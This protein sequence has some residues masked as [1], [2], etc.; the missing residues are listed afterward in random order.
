MNGKYAR[1]EDW[2]THR[3]RIT[4]LYYRA[5]MSLRLVKQIMQDEHSFLANERMYKTRIKKWNL[6]K[7]VKAGEIAA[8][9]RLKRDA[10]AGIQKEETVLALRDRK[11]EWS[12]VENHLK[13]NPNR[14]VKL[15]T[16]GILEIGHVGGILVR[17]QSPDP[18]T[19]ARSV[20]S[21]LEGADD[22]RVADEITRLT[23]DYCLSAVENSIWV[24]SGMGH[25]QSTRG[26]ALAYQR[27]QRWGES[28]GLALH[29]IIR[30]E[31]R[32]G[33]RL[34]NSCLDRLH[35]VF[36]D[37]DPSLL[38]HLV[39][40][41]VRFGSEAVPTSLRAM[42]NSYF[43]EL[44]QTAL[45]PKHPL[46]LLWDRLVRVT[47]SNA[48]GVTNRFPL[49]W[50]SGS[51]DPCFDTN[52]FYFNYISGLWTSPQEEVFYSKNSLSDI[53]LGFQATDDPHRLTFYLVHLT[54]ALDILIQTG[55]FEQAETAIEALLFKA[56]A[57][58]KGPFVKAEAWWFYLY[59]KAKLQGAMGCYV[60]AMS[61]ASDLC[62]HSTEAYGPS[63]RRSLDALELRWKTQLGIADAGEVDKLWREWK[64]TAARVV[65]SLANDIEDS[66]T[67]A[68][69]PWNNGR[70][71]ASYL[72]T[73]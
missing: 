17:T 25:Y 37:E 9:V 59:N 53:V 51:F 47:R 16:G 49:R 63:S 55:N 3:E 5:G 21:P 56:R 61:L 72:V 73:V 68:N 70:G 60:E 7:Y 33:F 32:S 69:I 26:G 57:T 28:I 48:P 10:G 27:L 19:A 20:S 15:G 22:V 12:D 11:V 18:A 34:L 40:V 4:Q 13:R 38:V 71:T 65:N 8:K 24:P 31:M 35:S 45:G 2:E 66:T 30:S 43:R 64:D 58:T 42:L 52:N 62:R 50:M 46:T 1:E 36:R 14:V 23:R 67:E 39:Q 54:Q 44:A 41:F 29:L 6:K